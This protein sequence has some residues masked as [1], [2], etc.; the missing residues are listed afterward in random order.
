MFIRLISRINL[1]NCTLPLLTT[2]C[3][4]RRGTTIINRSGKIKG[5]DALQ[6]TTSSSF[7]SHSITKKMNVLVWSSSF[8]TGL[9]LYC[10]CKYI[11]I[12]M[13]MQIQQLKDISKWRKCSKTAVISNVLWG[14]DMVSCKETGMPSGQAWAGTLQN[15]ALCKK[16]T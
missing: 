12:N 7:C 13:S 16:K 10:I 9:W 3:H 6:R 5:E 1:L 15:T 8:I 4:T 2:R 14:G 11:F